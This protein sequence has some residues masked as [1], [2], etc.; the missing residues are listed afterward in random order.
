MP[1]HKRGPWSQTEDQF[2]LHLVNLH[3]AHNWVR[4]SA[5]IQ[6]R[7]P[8]QCRE[9]YHQNLKPNLNHDPITPEEG[10]LIEQMVG[11]MGK[12]WAEIA[13]RLR[14]R[15]DNAVK[16]WW[17]GGMN[18]RRRSTAPRRPESEAPQTQMSAPSMPQPP[19]HHHTLPSSY[20]QQQTPVL[21]GYYGQPMYSNPIPNGMHM[22]SNGH[23][24][25]RHSGYIETPLPSPSAFSQISADGAP[26]L[27]SDT[28]S[29]S[30]RSPFHG[31]SS[32]E[33]PPL[34]GSRDSRRA[35]QHSAGSG[36]RLSVPSS[37]NEIDF[38][39]PP[40]PVMPKHHPQMLQEAFQPQRSQQIGYAPPQP[41]HYLPSQPLE[42]IP[43]QQHPHQQHQHQQHQHQQMQQYPMAPSN[44]SR[45]NS[46]TQ[47][48]VHPS[49]TQV[50]TM[51]QQQQQPMQPVQL[52]S[53]A[54]L[55]VMDRSRPNST[56][57]DPA[58]MQTPALGA[59]TLS[60]GSP[61]DKMRLSNLT[62]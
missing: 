61:R 46:Y 58:L 17:N 52:P 30:G 26:S 56:L 38:S 44:F 8:K 55:S 25:T 29:V 45:P 39:Q 2:L 43:V 14:G 10:V 59:A 22:P 16:N 47:M 33:L 36:L 13:R 37:F 28:S 9:R 40:M 1:Q 4:I 41:A 7:S 15:S 51:Q 18:R 12:R 50:P 53:I 60:D 21:Q 34:G 31:M 62:H 54:N 32:V 27:V 20:M 11:D 19:T 35:S 6:T 5:T 24:Y 57:I 23:I 42:T 48:L 49:Q 3:G